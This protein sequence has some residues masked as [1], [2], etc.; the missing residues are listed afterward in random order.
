[1]SMKA[2][3]THSGRPPAWRRASSA[4]PAVLLGSA[5]G[6]GQRTV[7]LGQVIL[8]R[9]VLA[10]QIALLLPADDNLILSA[11]ALP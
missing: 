9:A 11:P 10:H 3:G 5:L 7:V 8:G 1:M 2:S 4:G 6:V